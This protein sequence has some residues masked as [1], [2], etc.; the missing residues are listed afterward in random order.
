M[1][2]PILV[3]DDTP[4]D[5][6]ELDSSWWGEREDIAGDPVAVEQGP[7]GPVVLLA[8]RRVPAVRGQGVFHLGIEGRFGSCFAFALKACGRLL[9]Q[10]AEDISIVMGRGFGSPQ[11]FVEYLS[12]GRKVLDLTLSEEPFDRD[13]YLRAIHGKAATR[14]AIPDADY[15][16][17]LRETVEDGVRHLRWPWNGP[18]AAFLEDVAALVRQKKG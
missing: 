17:A 4:N 1:P 8:G 3:F 13:A 9:E 16:T 18:R 7:D 12:D 10:G 15:L 11:T 5:A 6:S 14:I 2:N